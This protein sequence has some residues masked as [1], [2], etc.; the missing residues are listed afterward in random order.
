MSGNVVFT[1][2][3]KKMR[4]ARNLTMSF[5]KNNGGNTVLKLLIFLHEY[6]EFHDTMSIL[7]PQIKT[8]GL[9]LCCSD[10]DITI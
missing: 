1:V 9:Y 4:T 6:Y 5:A 8:T 7:Q 3:Y 10:T 2:S